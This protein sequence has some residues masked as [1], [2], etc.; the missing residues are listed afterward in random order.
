MHEVGEVPAG[1]LA[2]PLLADK[3]EVVLAEELHAH[4]GEDEDDDAEDEGQVGQGPH[5]VGHDCQNVVEGFPGLGQL[6]DTEQT[7]G[8]EHG[9]ALDAVRQQLHQGQ[10][11][12]QE[13][14]AVPPVLQST[15]KGYTVHCNKS[16]NQE[17]NGHSGGIAGRI[18]Y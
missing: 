11:H 10:G 13:V 16:S 17:T 14:E 3:V 5:R 8:A 6:E 18:V 12:D 9:E 2:R 15:K 4:D 1:H 7:E